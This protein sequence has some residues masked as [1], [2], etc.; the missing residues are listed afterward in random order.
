MPEKDKDTLAVRLTV[1][2]L[3]RIYNQAVD[4]IR[5][6]FAL[7][8]GAQE[9]LSAAFSTGCYSV[10]IRG[11]YSRDTLNFR[12]PD[13]VL[14]TL[15]RSCWRSIVQRLE[16]HRMMSVAR[17]AELERELEKGDLPEITVENVNAFVAG[18]V[19]NLEAMLTEAVTEVFEWLRPRQ[20]TQADK[21]K[22]NSQLEVPRRVIM[23]WMIDTWGYGEHPFRVN[24]GRS[25]DQL[26]ALDNVFSALDGKGQITKGNV[27][28]IC[29][30][31]N[32]SKDGTGETD[33]FRFRCYRNRNLHLEFKR[34]DLLARF[35]QIAGGA[36]LRPKESAA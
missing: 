36:R 35:N 26:I 1:T 24:Y 10:D 13:D 12:N 18:Y 33:Y 29:D 7:V 5:A 31:I 15:R 20:G 34:E 14:W 11:R 4:E 30:A 22:R 16:L 27:S 2:E 23:T 3:V 19:C 9:S 17:A 8:A 28:P 21:Y 25:R 32:T 6:G